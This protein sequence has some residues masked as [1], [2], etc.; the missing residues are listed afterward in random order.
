M[1]RFLVSLALCCSYA[2]AL[3]NWVD[4]SHTILL[5]SEV[6][7][8]L[9]ATH[10][11]PLFWWN[12]VVL[13]LEGSAWEQVDDFC[14]RFNRD[15]KAWVRKSACGQDLSQFE[16]LLRAW[17]A[18]QDRREPAPT[19]RELKAALTA[20]LAKASLPG[21]AALLPVLRSDPLGSYRK[22]Q[23]LLLARLQLKLET[24]HGYLFDPVTQRIAIP[25][26]LDFPPNE[27][28]KTKAFQAA[29][30]QALAEFKGLH[31]AGMIGPQAAT[32]SNERQIYQDVHM[33]SWAGVF[34]LL[35]QIVVAVAIR[36]WR[37]LLLAPPVILSTLL[38]GVATYFI[39]GR[40]HGLTLSFGPGII[41]L[42]LDHGLH[43]CLNPD[44]KGAWKAN[45]Y[46]LLTTVVALVAMLFSAIPFLRQLMVFS[47]LG[48]FFG[49]AIYWFLHRCFK[50]YFSVEP[51]MIEPKPN[52]L[53]LAFTLSALA[54]LVV[55]GFLLRPSFGMQQMNYQTAADQ[56][57]M[58]WFFAHLPSE[59]PLL[60]VYGGSGGALAPSL[61]QKRFA[62]EHKIELDT[63][64][65]YLPSVSEQE[66]HLKAWRGL[67]AEPRSAEE[68]LF[69]A[70]FWNSICTPGRG[71]E[72]LDRGTPPAYLRDFYF[73]QR[74][75]S[76]WHT[77]N[78]HQADLV[79]TVY[80]GLKSLVEIVNLFQ[81]LLERETRWS[82]PLS[83]FLA[84][85][86]LWHYYRDFYLVALS[87]V[88]F[89]VG[90]GVFAAAAM[91]FHFAIS[92]I[93]LIAM[94]ML[95]GLSL[96]YGIFAT[97]LYTG[98]AGP[99][100]PG[101]WTSVVFAAVVTFLG[102]LPLIFCHHPVLVHLGEALVC[103]TAGTILGSVWGIPCLHWII[104][105]T[106]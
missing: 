56:E 34:L 91:A 29:M 12:F 88:P 69:F 46:G 50:R 3:P 2:Q 13:H 19:K 43:S 84:T 21:A 65:R 79:R 49:F 81:T 93:S 33:I 95:F 62:Q 48:L 24:Q 90:M 99:T 80:P 60:Q 51:L 18:D 20:T 4:S 47:I 85:L 5:P 55:G 89:L 106:R 98:R 14:K 42:C 104:R 22:L 97:N 72:T 38:A 8:P 39:F 30:E 102:F 73:H 37:L 28:A 103:G 74:W 7:E 87:L 32:L 31:L 68:T 35:A 40:I 27:T 15:T 6:S 9:S 45:W 26:Q 77:Q 16:E 36:R 58:Q 63:A 61:A 64:S 59:S 100:G 25:I 101:V 82:I 41:G 23:D 54:A 94:V 57:L 105:E 70:P 1:T 92:F 86:L 11:F 66:D 52:R 17:A 78:P 10:E 67:C 96:D 53:K 76:L 83:I 71:A 44:W 75:V